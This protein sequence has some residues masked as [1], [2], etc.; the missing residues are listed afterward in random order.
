L[1]EFDTEYALGLP[2]RLPD[3]E[4]LLWQGRPQWRSLAVRAFHVRSVAIYFAVLV[5]WR[6]ET[7]LSD[8]GT[9]TS[10]AIAVAWMMPLALAA[11][12]V[13]CLLAWLSARSTI[14]T[15]T[16][17]RVVMRFGIALP[18]TLN[19]PF[20]IID[21]AALSKYRDSTGDIPLKLAGKDR[22]A[23]LVLWPHARPWRV[24]GPEPMLRSIGNPD[25]VAQVLS[26][27]LLAEAGQAHRPIAGKVPAEPEAARRSLAPAIG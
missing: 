25:Q 13:L 6:A 26:R 5:A 7:V 22:V 2:E 18:M 4:Q 17:Q 23:F 9:V 20:R 27:A 10:A 3:G 14:Y 16:S 21:A 19:I 1:S 11:L 24:D 12:A 8:G 15:V